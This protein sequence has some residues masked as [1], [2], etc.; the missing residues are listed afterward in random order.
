MNYDKGREVQKQYSGRGVVEEVT[1]KE[2][3]A[4]GAEISLRYAPLSLEDRL[5]IAWM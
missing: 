5:D 2:L 1:P 3:R 4:P